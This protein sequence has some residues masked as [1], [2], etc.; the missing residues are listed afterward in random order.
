ME[1][2]ASGHKP[3][4]KGLFA[5]PVMWGQ[6]HKGKKG[7]AYGSS[8]TEDYNYRKIMIIMGSQNFG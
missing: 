8:L 2:G 5:D 3:Q 4:G 6:R 7:R 1:Q